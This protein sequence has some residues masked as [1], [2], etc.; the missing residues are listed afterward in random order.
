MHSV[1]RHVAGGSN[2]GKGLTLATR[3][4]QTQLG[5]TRLNIASIF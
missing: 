4:M 5:V 1:F 3:D 2:T